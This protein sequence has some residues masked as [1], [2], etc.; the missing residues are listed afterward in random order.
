LHYLLQEKG[1]GQAKE[2]LQI[3]HQQAEHKDH[4]SKVCTP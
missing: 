3:Y 1:R 2:Q 4:H